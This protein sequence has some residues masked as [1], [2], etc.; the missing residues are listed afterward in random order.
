MGVNNRFIYLSSDRIWSDVH[1]ADTT[2]FKSIKKSGESKRWTMRYDQKS[3][4]HSV[5]TI[6]TPAQSET[7]LLAKY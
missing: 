3:S 7:Q 4:Y 5:C 2:G 1:K 6:L